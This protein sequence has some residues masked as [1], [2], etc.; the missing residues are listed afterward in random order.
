[1]KQVDIGHPASAVAQ[2]SDDAVP[3]I[4]T[5]VATFSAFCL[6]RFKRSGFYAGGHFPSGL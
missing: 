1:M 6:E 4:G 2:V 3:R 5:N